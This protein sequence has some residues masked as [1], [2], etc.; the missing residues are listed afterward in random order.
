MVD[1]RVGTMPTLLDKV[2]SNAGVLGLV[3][4]GLFVTG[5]TFAVVD[6]FVAFETEVVP[7]E[8]T[9]EFEVRSRAETASR[10]G[11]STTVPGTPPVGMARVAGRLVDRETGAPLR[12]VRIEMTA[13]SAEEGL[14][15]VDPLDLEWRDPE[16]VWTSDD[17]RFELLCRPAAALDYAVRAIH[18]GRELAAARIDRIYAGETLDAG[19]VR[20]ARAERLGFVRIVDESGVPV[21]G[22]AVSI[23]QLPLRF[24]ELGDV[25]MHGTR[26]RAV[27]DARGVVEIDASRTGTI[28]EDIGD[29]G[30]PWRVLERDLSDRQ[31][32]VRALTERV[33]GVVVDTRGRPQAGR[34]VSAAGRTVET[35]AAGRFAIYRRPEMGD[36]V[37]LE[38]GPDSFEASWGEHALRL[39]TPAMATARVVCV[40]RRG[41]PLSNFRIAIRRTDPP[42]TAWTFP[43]VGELR[44]RG[45]LELEIPAGEYEFVAQPDDEVV[46]VAAVVRAALEPGSAT[47]VPLAL[48]ES[49][50]YRVE[51]VDESGRPADD[52]RVTVQNR[53]FDREVAVTREG[54]GVYSFASVA[55]PELLRFSTRIGHRVVEHALREPRGKL[56][57]VALVRGHT[58]WIRVR[59]AD[60]HE[61]DTTGRIRI[62]RVDGEGP[63]AEVEL[64]DRFSA[65]VE[66]LFGVRYRVTLA[67][68]GDVLGEFDPRD[69]SVVEFDATQLRFGRVTLRVDAEPELPDRSIA[70]LR[71]VDRGSIHG[72]SEVEAGAVVFLD[73]RPGEYRLWAGQRASERTV[74]I[75]PGDNGLQDVDVVWPI[76]RLRVVGL[77][78]RVARYGRLELRGIGSAIVVD[79]DREGCAVVAPAPCGRVRARLGPSGPQREFEV[80]FQSGPFDLLLRFDPDADSVGRPT[81]R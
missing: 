63:D 15:A 76:L 17:G 38:C 19:D 47:T 3:C 66:G 13:W 69:G 53:P 7:F 31:I 59:F 48:R 44:E 2:M 75:G 67:G 35:D 36:Q 24:G 74:R 50:V 5:L 29:A 68:V 39:K 70:V 43:R 11:A 57:R 27:S 26:L 28:L 12:G 64:N 79:L 72:R 73:V 41:N 22:L 65:G 10:D 55:A 14:V 23:R 52:I 45:V 40:D 4:A 58:V 33:E 78:G 30:T 62:V 37:V 32:V 56:Q 81:R 20:L 51:V 1:R 16:P 18:R 25:L 49:V 46:G 34:Q 6:W 9:T 80:P 8:S 54:R 21:P 71:D 42:G 61:P 77:D 60:G